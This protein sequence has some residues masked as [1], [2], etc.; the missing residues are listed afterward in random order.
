MQEEVIWACLW[1]MPHFEH[2]FRYSSQY[3]F[4][5]W[6]P[7]YGVFILK[8]NLTVPAGENSSLKPI[9]AN[10][11]NVYGFCAYAMLV[12]P[13]VYLHNAPCPAGTPTDCGF[14]YS[15]CYSTMC[16]RGRHTEL[17]ELDVHRNILNAVRSTTKI[18]QKC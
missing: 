4:L 16:R 10:C 17:S 1:G 7:L 9:T 15:I 12:T 8:W 2:K 13:A 5:A 6:V 3:T 18:R 14:K 11:C